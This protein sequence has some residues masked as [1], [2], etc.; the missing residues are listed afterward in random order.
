MD[1]V[2]F[3]LAE[4]EAKQTVMSAFLY[5]LAATHPARDA[6]AIEFRRR[7]ENVLA[8]WALE[9]ARMTDAVTD[10][11]RLVQHAIEVALRGRSDESP[12]TH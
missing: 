9:P 11:G 4:L 1:D 5:A 7:M 10:K 8:F 3:R 2:E 6:V 12:A